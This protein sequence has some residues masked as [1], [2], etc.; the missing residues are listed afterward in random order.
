MSTKSN[1]LKK[2]ALIEAMEKS[3]G[4]V[5][6]ACKSVDVQ[7]ST[8]Y[9]WLKEDEDFRRAIE[10]IEDV[11]LDFVESKLHEQIKENNT[12][13]TI[14]YLK[15][16]GKGRGYIERSE[17]DHT[18]KGESINVISLGGGEKPE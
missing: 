9:K 18:T 17:I 15:T 1:T 5:T 10:L 14:F 7:R 8:Y 13:A 11:A 12:P 16:K 4:I 2:K 3:L 6:K